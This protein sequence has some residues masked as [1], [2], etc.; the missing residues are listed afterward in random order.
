MSVCRCG[1][2]S[3]ERF[4]PLPFLHPPSACFTSE[5]SKVMTFILVVVTVPSAN[6]M[7]PNWRVHGPMPS[8]T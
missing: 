2:R 5:I 7:Q 8:A 4:H 3:D 6:K 1:T